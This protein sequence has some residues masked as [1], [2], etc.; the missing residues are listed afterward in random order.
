MKQYKCPTLGDCDKANAGEIFQRDL[1]EDLKC[2][3]CQ[4]LLAA[5]EVA[6]T[7]T[8]GERKKWLMI[9]AAAAFCLIAGTGYYYASQKNKNNSAT[10][11]TVLKEKEPVLIP[12][13]AQKS[14]AVEEFI[15]QE[16]SEKASPIQPSEAEIK[17]LKKESQDKL[18]ASDAVGAEQA[19]RRAA[20]NEM[21]KLGIAQMAQGKFDEA[22]KTLSE[23]RA[24]DPKQSLVYYNT[25]ILRLKQKRVDDA[26]KEFEA[27]FL[28]G[29]K[30]YD[31]IDQDPDLE[32]LRKDKR[33]VALLARYRH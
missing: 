2:P 28:N 16:T 18:V 25:A 22:D 14:I 19:S 33:F 24:K 30:Y 4:T 13:T 31:K 15:L 17:R 21:M 29:F 32:K 7:N 1:G 6:D 11:S 12:A 9:I 5:V 3:G 20:A 26:L 27:S 23:A 10:Q 8:S